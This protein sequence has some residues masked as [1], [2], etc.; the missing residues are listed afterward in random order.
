MKEN[1]KKNAKKIFRILKW[2]VLIVTVFF[3]ILAI[4]TRFN[5]FKDEIFGFKTYVI[6]S[7]SMNPK[8]KVGDIIITKKV[9]TENLKPNDVISYQGLTSD[10]KDKIITH[11]IEYVTKED[12]RYIFYTKGTA[13]NTMDPAVYEE[14]IYGKMV[15]KSFVF[16]RISRIVRTKIGF[17]LIVLIPILFMCVIEAKEI[18]KIL[19]KMIKKE[20]ICDKI[21][22][23]KN[24][25]KNDK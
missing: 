6:V 5:I 16:S 14:Q 13:N 7:D 3:L 17:L 9:A 20:K 10:F 19:K 4:N 8:L 15:Y 2:V 18:K 22:E 24:I 21:E 23:D 1:F 11:K 12:K 25:K